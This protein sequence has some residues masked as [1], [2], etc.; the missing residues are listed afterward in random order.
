MMPKSR[1]LTEMM[2]MYSVD[3]VPIARSLRESTRASAHI[4]AAMR[5]AE[6]TQY[7]TALNRESSRI[8]T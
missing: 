1:M 7:D 6:N 3:P 5:P 4:Q 8:D 2:R